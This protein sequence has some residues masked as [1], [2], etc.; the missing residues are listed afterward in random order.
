[1]TIIDLKSLSLTIMICD[2][3]KHCT[4]PRCESTKH[5]VTTVCV[6]ACYG[7]VQVPTGPWFCRK[8]ESQER[9]ARVVSAST[10][11]HQWD[12]L[13]HCTVQKHNTHAHS[14]THTCLLAHTHKF[15]L[16]EMLLPSSKLCPLF[17]APEV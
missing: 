4:V 9:A 1:M 10:H 12:A 6:P 17:L 5:K 8:C 14:D 11:P 15:C 16:V 13:Y 3:A 7:I 2:G